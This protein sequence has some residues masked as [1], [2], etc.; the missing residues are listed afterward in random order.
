MSATATPTKRRVLGSLDANVQMS[1][2]SPGLGASPLKKAGREP[3]L[4][5]SRRASPSPRK[6]APSREGTPRKRPLEEAATALQQPAVK[7]LCSDDAAVVVPA[8][9]ANAAAAATT[10]TTG[11]QQTVQNTDE[12][13]SSHV[14]SGFSSRS[15]T[16]DHRNTRRRMTLTYR[17]ERTIR[18]TAYHR[19]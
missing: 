15:V 19:W 6:Q 16:F 10:A 9:E 17:T 13:R 2:R 12:V 11:R 3:S 5:L 4:S 14:H 1:P 18:V 8:T 7:K